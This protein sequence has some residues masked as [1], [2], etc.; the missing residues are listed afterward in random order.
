MTLYCK[1]CGSEITDH[2][3]EINLTIQPHVIQ[4]GSFWA[5]DQYNPD[6]YKQDIVCEPCIIKMRDFVRGKNILPR[7]SILLTIKQ[8]IS[9]FRRLA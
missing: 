3:G 5:I 1:I 4:D 6:I 8:F 9:K 7:K 2:Y